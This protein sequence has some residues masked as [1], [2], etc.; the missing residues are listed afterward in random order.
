MVIGVTLWRGRAARPRGRRLPPV[1]AGPVPGERPSRRCGGP[2]GS[3]CLEAGFVQRSVVAKLD[4]HAGERAGPAAAMPSGPPSAARSAAPSARSS[5]VTAGLTSAPG[6]TRGPDGTA[7]AGARTGG[8]PPARRYSSM[9]VFRFSER[10]PKIACMPPPTSTT[11][12]APSALRASAL[13]WVMSFSST[14]RRVMQASSSVMFPPP[15]KASTSRA[16]SSR[17]PPRRRLRPTSSSSRP[18]VLRLKRTISVRNSRS[19]S[20]PERT[21]HQKPQSARGVREEHE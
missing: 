3:G 16:P 15:P 2:R 1:R 17:R 11:P 4:A 12:A 19:T 21:E 14:R 20:R 18:G 13:A 9:S 6:S 7:V 10:V 8:P 5:E